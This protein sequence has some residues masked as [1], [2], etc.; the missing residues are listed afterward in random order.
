MESEGIKLSTHSLSNQV[1]T[2]KRCILLLFSCPY[3]TV[4]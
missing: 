1:D 2:C 4:C 3:R